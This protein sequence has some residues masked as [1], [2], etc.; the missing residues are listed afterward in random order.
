VLVHSDLGEVEWRDG[1]EICR[2]LADR[3]GAELLVVRREAGGLMERWEQRW[4]DNVA[5][6][7][8]LSCVKLIMPW[9]APGMRFCTSELKTD[10]ICRALVRRFPGRRIVSA[11]GIR[12]E[13]STDRAKAPVS[14]EQP[15]LTRKTLATSGIN[16]NPIKHFTLGEVIDR[17]QAYGFPL[18][19]AYTVYGSSRYSCVYCIYSTLADL[20]ASARCEANHDVYRRTV[21]L[22]I[23]STFS[24]Q[25]GRW[26]GDAAPHL[27]VADMADRLAVVK[28]NAARREAAESRVPKHLLYTKGW[29]TCIPTRAEAE[30]LAGVRQEVTEAVGLSPTFLEPGAIVARYQY[31]MAAKRRKAVR[32]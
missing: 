8:S 16:W 10:V 27:L 7:V 1:G 22:E 12:A 26:L 4:R 30:L 25:G 6:Y 29:P 20:Q 28:L 23:N 17:H 11:S 32:S 2:R 14:E 31:L 5:R 24:F 13:E 15:K 3:L 9:S 21:R 19:P 18:A